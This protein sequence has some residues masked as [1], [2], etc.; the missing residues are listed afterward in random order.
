MTFTVRPITAD[1]L[2][3]FRR[4]LGLAFAFDPDEEGAE[5]FEAVF[6]L[7]RSVCAFEGAAMVGTAGAF[8][9]D[10]TVPGGGTVPTA[11]TTMVT[12][13]ATHRRQGAL[14]A[15]LRAHLS[16]ARRHGDVLAGL[17]ASESNIYGRFG[18]GA[19][20][21]RVNAVLERKHA[22]LRAGIDAPGSV[23]LIDAD[24]ASVLLPEAYDRARLQRPGTFARRQ[25][26]W[27]NRVLRDPESERAGASSYRYSVYE[28]EGSV[29]GYVRYR[30][31]SGWDDDGF[32]KGEIQIAEL[33]CFDLNASIGLW[34][35]VTGID[36]VRSIGYW[37][38]PVDDPL[39]WLLAD[40]RRLT[41]RV[42]DSLW[43]RLVDVPRALAGRRY[44]SDGNLLIEV[45]DEFCPE[46]SGTYALEV[47]D[48]RGQCRA[49]R[50]VPELRLPTAS[51]AAAYL[52]GNPIPV[53][54]AAGLVDGTGAALRKAEL[55]FSWHPAPWCQE[56]F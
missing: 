21:Y 10:L 8:S 33:Q 49:V 36:L 54:A 35:Y 42:S 56:I 29:R 28:E 55:M 45:V 30:A 18:Y 1:E 9:L 31:K 6:E 20:A 25:A 50:A 24:E 44:S 23:R 22:A 39:P 40:P 51:L 11:G 13:L 48:G 3:T 26:W 32:P 52:G 27:R 53:L 41:R 37:N 43:L 5:A 2:P 17:W 4:L 19:A 46:N 14:R 34:R 15:M 38:L 16:E 47:H 12:V 7:D